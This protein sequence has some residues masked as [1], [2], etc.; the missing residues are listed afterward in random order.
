MINEAVH[1]R[2]A[3]DGF[4]DRKG[5][6]AGMGREIL[7]DCLQVISIDFSNA[8]ILKSVLDVAIKDGF[9]VVS[10]LFSQ[11]DERKNLNR[12]VI[13][14]HIAPHNCGEEEERIL[15]FCSVSE[16]QGNHKLLAAIM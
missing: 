10:S 13:K 12:E 15:H 3:E 5:C 6:A 14:V 16:H 1:Q 4:D 7:Q 11:V 8:D 9:V 2:F